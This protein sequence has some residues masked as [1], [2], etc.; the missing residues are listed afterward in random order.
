MPRLPQIGTDTGSWGTLLNEFLRVSH[1]ED[2]SLRNNINVINVKDY[3]AI[4]NGIVDDTLAIQ[5][6]IQAAGSNSIVFFPSGIYN[7]TSTINLLQDSMTLL[8]LDAI[9]LRSKACG[10]YPQLFRSDH[11]PQ[12]R[13]HHPLKD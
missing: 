4:G 9:R 3:G 10:V 11:L 13:R 7:V 5:Q 6:A 1:R 8:G 12:I 2:G